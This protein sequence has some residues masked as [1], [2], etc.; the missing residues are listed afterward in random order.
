MFDRNISWIVVLLMQPNI[1]FLYKN[2]KILFSRL[3]EIWWRL[4]ID[5]LHKQSIFC[6]IKTKN[7]LLT[8]GI[9]FYLCLTILYVYYTIKTILEYQI[10]G[11]YIFWINY[12]HYFPLILLI[13]NYILGIEYLNF[14]IYE[15]GV[16]KDVTCQMH[17]DNLDKLAWRI[18]R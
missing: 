9:Y 3:S 5:C 11:I 12:G 16:I 13:F 2:L 17:W 1:L 4:K 10:K 14:W 7:K 18:L 15:I 8:F 6:N